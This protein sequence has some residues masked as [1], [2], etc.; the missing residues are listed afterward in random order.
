MEIKRKSPGSLQQIRLSC[1][2]SSLTA[3]IRG[4]ISK[5]ISTRKKVCRLDG[6]LRT[7]CGSSPLR[8]CGN[9]RPSIIVFRNFPLEHIF[10][11]KGMR[12]YFLFV[13]GTMRYFSFQSARISPDGIMRI[14][15]SGEYPSIQ[16]S[17]RPCSRRCFPS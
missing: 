8:S 12:G 2:L 13:P 16:V 7:V 17:S 14:Y 9:R 1:V 4:W 15:F 5:S 6:K 3:D 10:C 11:L